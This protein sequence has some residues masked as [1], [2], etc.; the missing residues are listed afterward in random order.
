MVPLD[1]HP[2]LFRAPRPLLGL[3]HLL[4]PVAWT[5]QWSW[6]NFVYHSD[7]DPTSKTLP[8]LLF[9]SVHLFG[10]PT[11]G[12]TSHKLWTLLFPVVYLIPRERMLGSR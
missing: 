7:E 11:P 10:L 4:A 1:I 2:F 5:Y 12:A 8:P 3:T 6:D 9:T